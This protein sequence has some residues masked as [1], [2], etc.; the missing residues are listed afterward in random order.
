MSNSLTEAIRFQRDLYLYWQEVVTAG[1]LPLNSRGYLTRAAIRRVARRL[2]A[3]DG[4]A[5]ERIEGVESE[6]LRLFYLRRL[7][8]RLR[9]LER[10]QTTPMASI[11]VA[12]PPSEMGRY[13]ACT[14]SERLRISARVWIAGGWWPDRQNSQTPPPR[15]MLPAPPRVALARQRLLDELVYPIQPGEVV[16]VVAAPA[17]SPSKPKIDRAGRRHPAIHYPGSGTTAE[18]ETRQDALAGPLLWMGFVEAQED[19]DDVQDRPRIVARVAESAWRTYKSTPAI[20]ALH[21][22][23]E[24]RALDLADARRALTEVHGRIVIQPNFEIIAFPPLT[25]PVLAILNACAEEV[26]LERTARFRLTRRAFA[27]A[28]RRHW[29]AMSLS[30]RLESEAGTPLP[31]NVRV[32]LDDWE[33]QAERLRVTP[34]IRLLEVRESSLLDALLADR[35]MA[36]HIRQRITSVTAVVSPEGVADVRAWLLRHGE[37]PAVKDLGANAPPDAPL[38]ESSDG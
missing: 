33:R 30:Q 3:V 5:L 34:N 9:L 26:A 25:G 22:E 1:G 32:T 10:T 11:L 13:L 23:R 36:S 14:L 4:H 7:L 18:E 24:G 37:L 6:Q 2:A 35:S 38:P 15:L 12:A 21:E 17:L 20:L 16:R 27:I 31:E 8:E 19:V 28:R 29:N